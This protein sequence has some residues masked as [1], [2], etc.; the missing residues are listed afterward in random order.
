[1]A[2]DETAFAD[3]AAEHGLELVRFAGLVCG[4]AALAEDLVQDTFVALYRRYGDTLPLAAPLAY[5]RKS[6]VNAAISHARRRIPEPTVTG[7]LPDSPRLDVIDG[8]EQDAM[9]RALLTLAERQRAVLVLRYYVDLPDQQ[10]ATVLGCRRAT[11][12]SLARS[13][14]AALRG[15]DELISEEQS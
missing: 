5:A 15:H 4:D 13:A 6:I 9:W 10:I 12:R 14:L 8:G 7:E 1:M 3:F 11:V 2:G